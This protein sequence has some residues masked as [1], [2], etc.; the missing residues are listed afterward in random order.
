MAALGEGRL[1][2]P[3]AAEKH[4][5]YDGDQYDDGDYDWHRRIIAA[6]EK[7]RRDRRGCGR[8]SG[9]NR[10][11][12]D[13]AISRGPTKWVGAEVLLDFRK[14]HHDRSHCWDNLTHPQV[15]RLAQQIFVTATPG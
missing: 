4:H 8:R 5:D 13:W 14:P 11:A 7:P 6:H 10:I 9:H 1:R 15:D 12:L 2:L 3:A